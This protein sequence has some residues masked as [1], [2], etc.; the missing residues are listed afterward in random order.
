MAAV[1]WSEP[2]GPAAL[3]IAAALSDIDRLHVDPYPRQP[4]T[5]QDFG[6]FISLHRVGQPEAMG[7]RAAQPVYWKLHVLLP[8]DASGDG[9]ATQKILSSLLGAGPNGIIGK[10]RR[11]PLRDHGDP[12]VVDDLEVV[13]FET[14]G[15]AILTFVTCE[16]GAYLTLT[17]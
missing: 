8:S 2:I 5:L 14:A 10:L 17:N 3:A 1:E 6:G 7:P 9:L 11:T 15:K 13:P 12:R 4:D 16:I